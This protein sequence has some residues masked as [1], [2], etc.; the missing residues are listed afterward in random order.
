M[1]TNKEGQD[2]ETGLVPF[3]GAARA[4]WISQT[5]E[6]WLVTARGKLGWAVWD[7]SMVYVTG[8]AA[9]AK[10]DTSEFLVGNQ[11]GTGH[12]ESNTRTGWT[13]GAG[14]EYALGYGWSIKGEYLYVRFEDYTT[15][16]T[17]PFGGAGLNI[18]PRN[19]RLDENVF[20]AGM[21]YKIGWY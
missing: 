16:T 6:R 18:A 20:R 14:Y 4:N 5:Q 19:N 13:V 7:K 21:N 11:T 3:L 9:W 1:V 15:F 12:Q 17:P 10:I 8:G 2:F